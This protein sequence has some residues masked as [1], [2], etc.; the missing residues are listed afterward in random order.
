MSRHILDASHETDSNT[1]L[2]RFVQIAHGNL[3][4]RA[5][6]QLLRRPRARFDDSGRVAGLLRPQRGQTA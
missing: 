6:E 1:R 2:R 4:H 3:R 5:I